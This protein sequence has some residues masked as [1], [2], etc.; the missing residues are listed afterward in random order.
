MK[1][2]GLDKLT[3]KVDR[4]AKMEAVKGGVKEAGLLIKGR[5]AQYPPESEANRWH[6][7]VYYDPD[8]K[9]E[10]WIVTKYQRNWGQKYQRADGSVGG[11]KTSENLGKRWTVHY[12]NQGMTAI[13]G[14]N[15][16]YAPFVQGDDTQAWFHTKRN[17]KTDK[18]VLEESKDDILKGL[19]TSIKNELAK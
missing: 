2:I 10:R 15:A 16:T 5:I 8:T 17:W 1:I 14:N 4:L 9:K 7:K 12:R 11:R 6:T 13:V 3:K 19:H 18:I